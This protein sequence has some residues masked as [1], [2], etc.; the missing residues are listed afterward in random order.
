MG[1]PSVFI[2]KDDHTWSDRDINAQFS[3]MRKSLTYNTYHVIKAV[4]DALASLDLSAEK[5]EEIK[6]MIFFENAQKG[7]FE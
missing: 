2:T 1:N 4:K 5:I 7:L 6:N 3:R